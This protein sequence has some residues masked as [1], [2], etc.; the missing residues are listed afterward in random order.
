MVN[1]DLLEFTFVNLNV[2]PIWFL[3]VELT[4]QKMHSPGDP[5]VF[6]IDFHR[7]SGLMAGSTKG[8]AKNRDFF[9]GRMA[10]ERCTSVRAEARKD[11][12]DR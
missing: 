8:A 6:A 11:R 5:A 2:L 3:C 1:I 7:S 4:N 9:D 12:T 10:I